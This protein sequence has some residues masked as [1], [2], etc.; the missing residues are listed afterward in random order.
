MIKRKPLYP[1][2]S[3]YDNNYSATNSSATAHKANPAKVMTKL[4]IAT[5]AKCQ[6]AIAKVDN[7]KPA[8][9]PTIQ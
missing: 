7:K 5:S 2:F 1:I 8:A 4:M 6:C 9:K 3:V